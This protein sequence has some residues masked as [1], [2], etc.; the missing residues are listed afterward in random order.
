MTQG[1]RLL[2]DEFALID[3]ATGLAWPFPRPI[4][5]KNASAAILTDYAPEGRFGT[6][7]RGTPKGDIRHLMPDKRSIAA[8]HMP[9]RP[10]LILFPSFGHEAAIRPVGKAEMFVRLTQASTN[11]IALG[12][13]GFRA[14]TRLVAETPVLALDYPDTATALDLV[15]QAWAEAR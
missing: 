6:W 7:M 9:A 8:M 14:L 15:E 4:S 5:L 3:P 13:A 11:Y 12:E 10:A 2:G 1:W